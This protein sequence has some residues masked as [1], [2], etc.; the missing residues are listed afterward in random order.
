MNYS[1]PVVSIAFLAFSFLYIAVSS[2]ELTTEALYRKKAKALLLVLIA[3]FVTEG[4]V[5][6]LVPHIH[7]HPMFSTTPD[8]SGV[9]IWF[10]L[11]VTTPIT[12]IVYGLVIMCIL[13]FSKLTFGGLK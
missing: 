3:V 7:V 2:S 5:L 10:G 9:G 4:L 13:F 1:Y 11:A 8:F 6:W 12:V